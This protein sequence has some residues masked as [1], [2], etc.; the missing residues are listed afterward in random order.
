MFQFKLE[1]MEDIKECEEWV[2][3]K[4]QQVE[5]GKV[6]DYADFILGWMGA[7]GRIKAMAKAEIGRLE[8]AKHKRS[9]ELVHKNIQ[10]MS[11]LKYRVI[12]ML[13][14]TDPYYL[15]LDQRYHAMVQLAAWTE[16]LWTVLEI[17]ARTTYK[18]LEVKKQE[19]YTPLASRM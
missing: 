3:S 16:S 13:C 4:A 1:T 10:V 2:R 19:N 7:F 12:D 11:D 15:S 8:A 6:S 18:L 9:A 5:D 17:A 14:N